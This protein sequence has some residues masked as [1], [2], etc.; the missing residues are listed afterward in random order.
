LYTQYAD[1]S[2]D[3]TETITNIPL[4]I[5]VGHL[6]AITY[7]TILPLFLKW[8]HDYP[9]SISDV[10]LRSKNWVELLPKGSGDEDVN[11]IGDEFFS[12]KG[13]A[14][15]RQ[16]LPTK[17]LDL[18]LGISHSLRNEIED[19]IE[20]LELNNKHRDE[21]TSA[22]QPLPETD[23]PSIS[24]SQMNEDASVVVPLANEKRLE[25]K[26]QH[27]ISVSKLYYFVYYQVLNFKHRKVNFLLLPVIGLVLQALGRTRSETLNEKARQ[28]GLVSPALG[29]AR[30]KT[31]N[32][33][34]LLP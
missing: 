1:Y 19:Y 3:I 32:G 5:G 26:R 2:K 12:L 14:K 9:L 25:R 31:M 11:A 4:S 16:F 7:F 21:D 15:T 8:S 23:F 30:S 6:K 22:L 20:N 27:H 24:I 34:V 17:V 13:K 28:Q 10:K 33:K 18:Y 29:H